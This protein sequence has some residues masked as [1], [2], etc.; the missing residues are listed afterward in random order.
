M[1]LEREDGLL[2]KDVGHDLALARVLRA[3][4]R[5]EEPALDGDEG[6]VEVGLE[7]AGAMP[8]HDLKRVRVRDRE[9]V[10]R[11]ADE[12]AWNGV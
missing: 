4:A 2:G 11:D 12:C 9:V 10:G 8:V 3:R 6:V 7:R 5:V 1:R